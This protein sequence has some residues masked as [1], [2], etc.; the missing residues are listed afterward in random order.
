ML[1]RALVGVGVVEVMAPEELIEAAE[2]LSLE[3]PEECHLRNGV[4]PAARLEGLT[5]LFL[6]WRSDAAYAGFKKLL[7][8][9]GLLALLYPRQCVEYAADMGYTDAERCEWKPWVFLCT[10]VTGLVYVLIALHELR[11]EGGD[12]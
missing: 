7:G 2:R 3:N 4:V 5:W 10:R 12:S 9:L 8:V 11:R 6:A 1:R